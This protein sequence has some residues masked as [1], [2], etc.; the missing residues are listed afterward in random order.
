MMHVIP[1]K[2]TI[3]EAIDD[4]VAKMPPNPTPE[5]IFGPRQHSPY[6]QVST[7]RLLNPVAEAIRVH[8]RVCARNEV[9]EAVGKGGFR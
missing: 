4:V 1:P 8:T 7:G 5:S 9:L 6:V 3:A 2:R